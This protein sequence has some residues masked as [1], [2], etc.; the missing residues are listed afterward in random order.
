MLHAQFFLSIFSIYNINL[1]SI[2][3]QFN[4][5][6]VSPLLIVCIMNI[7]YL[8][9]KWT[10]LIFF[11]DFKAF[12]TK[13]VLQRAWFKNRDHFIVHRLIPELKGITVAFRQVINHQPV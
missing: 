7:F 3:N 13:L 6:K 12:S 11:K 1:Y 4:A 2:Y 5:S 10:E 8:S 9:R